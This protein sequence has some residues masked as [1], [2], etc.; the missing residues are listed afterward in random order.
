MVSRYAYAMLHFM[1]LSDGV[2]GSNYHQQP[3]VT[4]IKDFI[5]EM[6]NLSVF[7][8]AILSATQK[9]TQR[10]TLWHRFNNILQC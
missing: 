6:H 7:E 10:V 8:M 9:M 5:Q 3:R 1:L 4:R 2:P